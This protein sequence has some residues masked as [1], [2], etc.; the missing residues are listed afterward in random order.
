NLF[1]LFEIRLLSNAPRQQQDADHTDRRPISFCRRM[2]PHCSTYNMIKGILYRLCADNGVTVVTIKRASPT[3]RS[4]M[5]DVLA[6][7]AGSTIPHVHCR[8][9]APSHT[10][11][12]FECCDCHR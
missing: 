1:R 10:T 2:I 3:S 7:S 6:D 4:S 8:T 5:Q 12:F 9:A 11:P